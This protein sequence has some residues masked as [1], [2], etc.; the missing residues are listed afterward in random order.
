MINSFLP[1]QCPY[2]NSESFKKSGHTKSGV[3]RY[4]CECGKTFL[5]TTG[6]IFDEHRISISEWIEYCLSLFRHVSITADSWS[7]KNSFN[8]SRYWLEKLFLTL[9]RTQDSIVL[10]DKVWLD[11]TYYSIRSEDIQRNALGGK[12]SGISGN[13]ICIGA[14]TD[15]KQTILFVEGMGR[16]SQKRTLETYATH[17]EKSSTL[18]HDEESAHKKLVKQL[19]LKSIA[20]SSKSLKGIPDKDNPLYPINRVHAIMKMFLNAHSSFARNSLQGY[21]NLF[22]FVSNPP[23]DMLEKVELIINLAFQN[24]RLLRY[25]DFYAV[26]TSTDP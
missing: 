12:L 20:Y 9:E 8:T 2:C 18:I 11:E 21:L 22:T 3:Q 6:T 16:P 23:V 24:P 7:N 5:P 14:A 10:S 25:R 13:Q 4:K 19:D 15:K 1:H 17:I 26:N